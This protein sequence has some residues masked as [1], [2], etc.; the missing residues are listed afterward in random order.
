[1]YTYKINEDIAIILFDGM[2]V[3]FQEFNP[4]N[5]E[6]FS[7]ETVEIWAKEEIITLNKALENVEKLRIEKLKLNKKL[8][9]ENVMEKLKIDA[10]TTSSL[11]FEINAGDDAIRDV[12]GLIL[13]SEKMPDELLPFR[14]Y[15]DIDHLITAEQIKTIQLEI[16]QHGFSIYQKKWDLL[17]KIDNSTTLEELN[18]ISW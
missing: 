13:L 2:Q 7:N 14:G 3:L 10:H 8:E 4:E 11:G 17:K 18:N 16:Y 1:M 5:G 6:K 12:A 15:D 9:I